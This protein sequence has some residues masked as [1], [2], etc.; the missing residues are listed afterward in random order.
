MKTL[1]MFR[2]YSFIILGSLLPL[3]SLA[4]PELVKHGYPNCA[5]CHISPTGG[6]VLN[7]YGR[8]LSKELVS[9]WG[10]EGEEKTLYWIP[11]N[12]NFAM[13]G[14]LRWLSIRDKS[15]TAS[16]ER[17]INMQRDLEIA[18]IF[19]KFTAAITGG[20]QNKTTEP[21]E[22]EFLSR[23]HY[24]VYQQSDKLGFRLGKFYPAFGLYIPDHNTV[25]RRGLGFDQNMESYNL[26]SAW[27]NE[28]WNLFGTLI[29]GRPDDQKLKREKGLALTAAYNP[30]EKI[31]VGGSYYYGETDEIIRHLVG[32]YGIFGFSDKIFLLAQMN[33]VR[34]FPYTAQESSL[35]MVDYLRLDYE[36]WKGVHFYLTQE[37]SQMD[38]KEGKT[39]TDTWGLGFQFFPRPHLEFQII[40]QKIYQQGMHNPPTDR[41]QLLTHFYL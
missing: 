4:F 15:P 8:A 32:P 1:S 26:E 23:R 28:K 36:A 17:S 27:Q 10:Y 2:K 31:K 35:G 40:M 7:E 18:V 24:L 37:L 41:L 33:L 16:R 3:S 11:T 39:R 34:A 12:E 25:I 9:T 21:S 14:D 13:G 6:G 29:A 19:K 30:N 22:T 38:L 5:A 20:I